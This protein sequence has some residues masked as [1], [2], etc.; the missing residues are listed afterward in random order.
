LFLWRIDQLLASMAGNSRVRYS[1]VA[2]DFVFSSNVRGAGNPLV[3]KLEEELEKRG[4]GINAKKKV[5]H[6]Y[7][8]CSVD[9]IV[10]SISVSKP[11][12]T[13]ISREQSKKALALATNYVR[14]CKSVSAD[15]I[16]VVAAKRQSLLGWINY[17]RQAE[18]GPARELRRHLE[19]GDRHVLK[20]LR[21]LSINSPKNKWWVVNFKHDRNE[22]RRI[23]SVWRKRAARSLGD[24]M[25][26]SGR[27]LSVV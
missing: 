7:Q 22:P 20:T 2:D 14:A 27:A 11:R 18:L 10:H 21:S 13:S 5:K 4:I 8:T 17:C 12:G 25:E 1:R 9:R 19:A 23:A 6:G 26:S 24:S 15:S 16:E 3:A